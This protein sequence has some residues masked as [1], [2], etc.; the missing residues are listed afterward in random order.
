MGAL[1]GIMHGKHRKDGTSGYLSISM[2][3]TFSMS[4]TYVRNYIKDKKLNKIQQNVFSCLKNKIK[5]IYPHN[6]ILKEGIQ[7][8]DNAIN[9]TETKYKQ[10]RNKIK[11]IITSP[12]YL[13][14][15]NYG[16]YNWIRLWLLDK[17]SYEV[18][19]TLRLDNAYIQSQKIKLSDSLH[20]E[21]YINLMR[22]LIQSW[23]TLLTDDGLAVIV[24]GDVESHEKK[25]TKYIELAETV[26]EN[27]KNH[28][29]LKLVSILS[30][31]IDG[32]KKVTKIWGSERK[33]TATKIDKLLILS[34]TGKLPDA[35]IQNDIQE[36]F[37]KIYG[38]RK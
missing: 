18:D 17:N 8:N 9:I 6:E 4:P 11:L 7:F 19:K 14:V 26:W 28:T 25:K 13:K 22:S 35:N 24:I 31:T 1:M 16:K 20:L 21:Q 29:N 30:D 33:G 12:P 32:S 15:I 34:K 3:N 38:G 10:Y 27:V 23:E 5:S 2:P 36:H 37:S